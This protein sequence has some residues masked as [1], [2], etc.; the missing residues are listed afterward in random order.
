MKK[1]NLKQSKS[2]QEKLQ[3]SRELLRLYENPGSTSETEKFR[4]AQTFNMLNYMGSEID[5]VKIEMDEFYKIYTGLRNNQELNLMNLLSFHPNFASLFAGLSGSKLSAFGIPINDQKA[6][7]EDCI[8]TLAIIV[9]LRDNLI[10]LSE[11]ALLQSSHCNREALKLL[12]TTLSSLTSGE[13]IALVAS[14]PILF[15]NLLDL[16]VHP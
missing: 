8:S 5:D 1:N 7:A 13:Q 2:E 16:V 11:M 4:I 15:R 10:K 3:I 12:N 9:K 6:I 14:D